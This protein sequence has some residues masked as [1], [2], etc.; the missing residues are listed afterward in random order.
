[1]NLL[2]HEHRPFFVANRQ[3]YAVVAGVLLMILVGAPVIFFVHKQAI[4]SESS[5]LFQSPTVLWILGGAIIGFLAR[6][7]KDEA[8]RMNRV[9]A[10]PLI[11]MAIGVFIGAMY[12][13]MRMDVSIQCWPF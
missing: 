10:A 1:M 3:N 6:F 11:L 5:S 9:M 2:S 8:P 13:L 4:E 7:T 12:A